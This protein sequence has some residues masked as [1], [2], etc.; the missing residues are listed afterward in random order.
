MFKPKF[1]L[2]LKY[3]CPIELHYLKIVSPTCFAFLQASP[4]SLVGPYGSFPAAGTTQDLF[5]KNESPK[6]YIFYT[7]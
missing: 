3:C 4:A 2:M 6:E 7:L 5:Q 1:P